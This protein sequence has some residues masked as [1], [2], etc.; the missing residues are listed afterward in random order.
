MDDAVAYNV[1]EH[2]VTRQLSQEAVA[3]AMN[4][5]GFRWTGTLV[6]KVEQGKRPLGLAEA[7][8]LAIVLGVDLVA[9]IDTAPFRH[10]P[11][12]NV[13]GEDVDFNR[14]HVTIGS[15]VLALAEV[16][17]ALRQGTRPGSLDLPA[18][19]TDEAR[20]VLTDPTALSVIAGYVEDELARWE[21]ART[22]LR[23][24]ITPV[25]WRQKRAQL[26]RAAIARYVTDGELPGDTETGD[27]R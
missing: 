24:P 15:Q 27:N 16:D 23:Q 18:D 13:R 14:T 26:R 6:A 7:A 11:I 8:G 5:L 10:P 25:S 2:R 12:R 21:E 4:A 1:A 22:L 17:A 19:V 20:L 9:L 3:D